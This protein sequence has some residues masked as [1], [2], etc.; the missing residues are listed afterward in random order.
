MTPLKSYCAFVLAALTFLPARALASGLFLSDRGTRALGRGGAF[1]AGASGLD[2]VGYNPAALSGTGLLGEL[3]MPL[4]R[5]DYQRRLSVDDGTGT[6]SYVDERKIHGKSEP[7]PFPTMIAAYTIK[8]GFLTLAGGL[9]TPTFSLMSFPNTVGGQPSPARY[10]L[11]GFSDSRILLAGGW[12]ALHLNDKLSIGGGVHGLIGTFRSTVGF[13]LSPPDRVLAAPEDPDYDAV[14]RIS[15]GPMIAPSASGG[16][17]FKPN[18]RL[19]LGLSGELPIWINSDATFDVRLPSSAAFETV[20]VQGKKAHLDMRLPAILRSGIEFKPNK[21]L[22]VEFSYVR[23]FWSLH[24]AIHVRPLDIRIN[25]VP[26]GP[27][28]FTLPNIYI[29]RKFKD[30]NSFRLGAE[31]T[32]EL[33]G[34]PIQARAGVSFDQSAVPDPYL[35]LSSL[36]F[37][38]WIM[39]A[40]GSMRF[41]EHVR[42]DFTY[43][44]VR[45]KP[46][47]VSPDDARI[48]RINPLSGNAPE[49]HVNGGRY[50]ISA[51]VVSGALAIL[52]D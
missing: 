20:S 38:K 25:G 48:P 24:N 13:S 44:Y 29:P 16:I 19:A 47:S 3:T 6:T 41:S 43:A 23:E 2:A 46:T 11:S 21:R 12:M 35:S 50:T 42:G 4:I 30:S 15:V 8:S 36:D 5:A 37:N 49:E 18:D 7:I 9:V 32:D 31:F 39:A 52:F 26:G 14:G 33:F 28:S 10:T 27:A 34:K 51:H 1:V 17:Q 45:T 22:A 40:G